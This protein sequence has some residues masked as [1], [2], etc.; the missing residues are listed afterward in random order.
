M[1]KLWDEV[2]DYILFKMWLGLLI[3]L[4]VFILGAAFGV[5]WLQEIMKG[6]V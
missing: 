3:L 2:R 4:A 5:F 6:H 1:K